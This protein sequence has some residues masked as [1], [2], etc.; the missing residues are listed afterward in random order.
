MNMKLNY[1]KIFQL[2]DEDNQKDNNM[3]SYNEL[4][5]H[6]V[7]FLGMYKKLINYKP[8]SSIKIESFLEKE[9]IK[10]SSEEIQQVGKNIKYNRA[11]EL[12]QK[13][14]INDE[15]MIKCLLDYANDDFNDSIN[16]GISFFL[17]REEFEKC[18][19]LKKILDKIYDSKK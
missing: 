18:A 7:F 3:T 6:P 8:M 4:R 16:K 2:F 15:Y 1:T 17:E 10:I 9:N 12:I 11:F 5:E 13:F 19:F 14:N